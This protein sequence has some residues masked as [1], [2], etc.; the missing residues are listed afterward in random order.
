MKE[1]VR[2]LVD[3]REMTALVLLP[4]STPE[5]DVDRTFPLKKINHGEI[6]LR[7][8]LLYLMRLRELV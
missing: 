7:V 6:A 4:G 3:V 1:R 8:K 2:L 5:K